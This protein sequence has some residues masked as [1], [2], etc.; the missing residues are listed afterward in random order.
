MKRYGIERKTLLLTL[1]PILVMAVLLES[2]SIFTRFA[3]LDNSLLERS[4]LLTHQLASSCEYAVF[5]GN[6]TLLKQTVDAALSFQDVKAIAVFDAQAK[7]ILTSGIGVAHS[8]LND[9]ASF[10]PIY[11]DGEI[12]RLHEPIMATQINLDNLAHD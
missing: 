1:I 12:L 6:A 11:Q 10:A 2:Y 8:R 9:G 3:D 7:P 5:S 4:R